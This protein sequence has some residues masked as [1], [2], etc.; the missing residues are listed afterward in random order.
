MLRRLA[1]HWVGIKISKEHKYKVLAEAKKRELVT[2]F[3]VMYYAKET[4]RSA[5]EEELGRREGE[6]IRAYA[7]P[8]NS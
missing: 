2:T 8:L 5:L 6:L 4:S 3:D 1:Q 7:P